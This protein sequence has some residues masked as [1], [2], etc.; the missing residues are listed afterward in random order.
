[1]LALY[2]SG[3]VPAALAGSGAVAAKPAAGSNFGSFTAVHPLHIIVGFMGGHV[4]PGN[5]VHKEATIAQELR[6]PATANLHVLVFANRDGRTALKDLLGLIDQDGDHTIS[7]AERD[8]VSI[9]IYGH[10]WGASETVALARS[11]QR[12]GIPVALTVQVDSVQKCGEN[13][14]AIPS[15]VQEAVNLYQRGGLLRGRSSIHAEDATK[16]R[17]LV[18][19][20]YHYGAEHSVDIARFPW[21]ARTFMRQHIMIENDPEVWARVEG[22][23]RDAMQQPTLEANPGRV[24]AMTTQPRIHR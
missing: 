4:R 6:E 3:H 23:L 1:M 9:A 18:N 22:F 2:F 19:Q 13:D 14:R 20:Q 16:T 7:D 11:L 17:I 10:S 15:N 21:F 24:T 8:A 5:L 12:E